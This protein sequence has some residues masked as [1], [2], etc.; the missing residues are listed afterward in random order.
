MLEGLA[1]V[2]TLKFA[3]AVGA[4]LFLAAC[5]NDKATT[6]AGDLASIGGGSATPGRP[7]TAPP[8]TAFTPSIR[9]AP[10]TLTPIYP[11]P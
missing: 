3:V 8:T 5:A 6:G 9:R 11:L 2:R 7:T 10:W 1:S 4:A